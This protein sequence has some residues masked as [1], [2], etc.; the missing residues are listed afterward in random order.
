METKL[1]DWY[2]LASPT[3]N[4]PDGEIYIKYKGFLPLKGGF[5]R[6]STKRLKDSRHSVIWPCA[7]L[8]RVEETEKSHITCWLDVISYRY[9]TLWKKRSKTEIMRYPEYST[10]GDRKAKKNRDNMIHREGL[11][12][13]RALCIENEKWIKRSRQE[14]EKVLLR[15][16]EL[17]TGI[18]PSLWGLT[19]YQ[20]T[21]GVEKAKGIKKTR[22]LKRDRES[23]NQRV[24]NKRWLLDS[25]SWPSTRLPGV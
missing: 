20:T 14:Q 2:F 7:R 16:C 23:L 9:T 22:Q 8:T 1:E 3:I 18:S 6:E 17:T 19:F 21:L 5:C 4:R 10:R 24:S 12:P 13:D 11:L 15:E 25:S